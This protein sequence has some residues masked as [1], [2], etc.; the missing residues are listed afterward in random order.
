MPCWIETVIYISFSIIPVMNPNL[1]HRADWCE[2]AASHELHQ[3]QGGK[4]SQVMHGD[5]QLCSIAQNQLHY[6]AS[7]LPLLRSLV[8]IQGTIL[9]RQSWKHGSGGYPSMRY[10]RWDCVCFGGVADGAF[11]VEL[12]S[13]VVVGSMGCAEPGSHK[14]GKVAN[15]CPS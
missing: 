5:M 11:S 8:V 14:W 15:K 3:L 7:L 2:S 1:S 9:P 6:L 10:L 4:E 13:W 12:V